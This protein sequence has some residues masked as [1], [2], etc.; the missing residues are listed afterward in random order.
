MTPRRSA[1]PQPAGIARRPFLRLAFFGALGTAAVGSGARIIA[2]LYPRSPERFGSRI[3]IDRPDVPAPDRPPIDQRE[4]KFWIVRLSPNEGRD[5]D[6]ATPSDGGLLA[7]SSVCPHE[8][9]TITW[10]ADFVR[11]IRPGIS[12]AG[13]FTCPCGGSIF[14]K[15][16]VR[17]FGPAP[18]SMDRFALDMQP[19]GSVVIDPTRRTVGSIDN[20]RDAV[21]YPA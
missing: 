2:L 7:L 17:V 12:Q 5:R 9:C 4:A 15:A 10:R 6:D 1:Q 14:T 16:G 8:G 3:T 11:E 19:D 18:R 21:R 13:W 20:P